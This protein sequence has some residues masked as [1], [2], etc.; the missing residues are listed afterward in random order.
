MLISLRR[1]RGTCAGRRSWSRSR[2]QSC[3]W[4]NNWSCCC[5]CCH[6]LRRTNNNSNNKCSCCNHWRQARCGNGSTKR[7]VGRWRCSL[8][9]CYQIKSLSI[10]RNLYAIS[11]KT[12]ENMQIHI[13]YTHTHTHQMIIT[14]NRCNKSA[15]NRFMC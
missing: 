15:R 14:D 2:S 4:G 1:C 6:H 8:N 3:S 11:I 12:K 5:C 10:T 9:K 7:G 13:R